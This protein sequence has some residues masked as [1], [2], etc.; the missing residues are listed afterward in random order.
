VVF[1]FVAPET[2]WQA[3]IDGEWMVVLTQ[4]DVGMTKLT[5]DD[6]EAS[7][8]R[9]RYVVGTTRRPCRTSSCI[10]GRYSYR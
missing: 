6:S 2:V 7:L 1:E 10:T 5:L 3:V 8:S 4:D 9:F